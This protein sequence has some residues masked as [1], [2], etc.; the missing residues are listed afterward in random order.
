[1]TNKGTNTNVISKTLSVIKAFTDNQ[2]EWGVN[3]LARYLEAPASSVHRI[4]KILKS[5][6]ILQVS[7]EGKYKIG[8]EMVRIASIISAQTDVK[9]VAKPYMQR[10]SNTI[11]ESVYLALYHSR[12]KKLSF[13]DSVQS[14]NALQYILDIGVLQPVNVAASGKVILAY[15]SEEEVDSIF[16]TEGVSQEQKTKVIEE[17]KIIR[18]QG[19][20]ITKG[21]RKLGALSVGA[22][23][24]D[25]T[26][27]VI[28]S[29]ICV[30]PI[31]LFD[32][33]KKNIIIQQ[34]KEEAKNISHVLGF[35]EVD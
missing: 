22:P 8:S 34:V 33:N 35:H 14:E 10:L 4:L 6:N 11:N 28:G 32:N 13:I 2:D 5:E 3:E 25:A 9:S 17:I 20:A 26:K 7:A 15:L 23:I 24:F 18:E 31:N 19:Y 27:K 30:I 12:H 16:I 21:E 1:M 29:M